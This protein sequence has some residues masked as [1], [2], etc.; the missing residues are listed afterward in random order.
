MHP[1]LGVMPLESESGELLSEVIDFYA[2][3]RDFDPRF[4]G[5]NNRGGRGQRR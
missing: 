2:P 5:R 4:R 1:G 3:R